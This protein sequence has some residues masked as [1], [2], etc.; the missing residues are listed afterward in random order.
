MMKNKHSDRKKSARGP[1]FFRA[2]TYMR[3]KEVD[4]GNITQLYNA[5]RDFHSCTFSHPSASIRAS[6]LC[7]I[8]KVMRNAN[9]IDIEPINDFGSQLSFFGAATSSRKNCAAHTLIPA[10]AGMRKR[11]GKSQFTLIVTAV[12][13][14]TINKGINH[15][16]SSPFD[17]LCPLSKYNR[18]TGKIGPEERI[19]YHDKFFWG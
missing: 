8:N 17:K 5:S 19:M 2:I 11:T 4:N 7:M 15:G 14:D 12:R 16:I 10:I 18:K 6:N 1:R 9:N 3:R 13:K